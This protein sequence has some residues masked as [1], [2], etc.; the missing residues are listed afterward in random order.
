MLV[1]EIIQAYWGLWEQRF[2]SK[3][4]KGIAIKGGRVISCLFFCK[5]QNQKQWIIK[6]PAK[7]RLAIL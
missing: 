5:S 1:L 7:N 3:I 4:Y 6:N 2:R